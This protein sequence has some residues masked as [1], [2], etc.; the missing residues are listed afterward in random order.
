MA[1]IAFIGLGNMDT[2]VAQH[3]TAVRHPVRAYVRRSE[4]VDNAHALGIKPCNTSVET[5]C[6]TEV[7]SINA[8]S[9]AD[10]E[11]VLLGLGGIIHGTPRSVVHIDHSMTSAVATR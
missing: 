2:P 5:T 3:L 7:V 1:C 10:V 8:T 9:I 11:G 6:D 4:V